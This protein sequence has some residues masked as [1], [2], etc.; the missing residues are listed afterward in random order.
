MDSGEL[1]VPWHGYK[2]P[3]ETA[4]KARRKGLW[5]KEKCEGAPGDTGIRKWD[6]GPGGSRAAEISTMAALFCGRHRKTWLQAPPHPS[7]TCW[8]IIRLL[9]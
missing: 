9:S 8:S 6:P 5:G 1:R 3:R 4:K 7:Q 2:S